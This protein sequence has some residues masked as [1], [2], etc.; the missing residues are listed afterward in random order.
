[1]KKTL[2]LLPNLL[3][4]QAPVGA[5]LPPRVGEAVAML[6]GLIAESE[7]GGRAYLSLFTDKPVHT[8][9]IALLN[10][11]TK[12]EDYAFLLDPIRKGET[13]GVVSDAGLPY[14][15]DPAA[16]LVRHA[17]NQGIEVV[18]FPGPSS[19]MHALAMSGYPGQ[20]FTFHGYL[21]KE[22]RKL[23]GEIREIENN[24]LKQGYTQIF[25]ESPHRNEMLLKTLLST[26]SDSVRLCAAV[27]LTGKTQ[28]I[29]EGTVKSWR[30]NPLPEIRKRPAIFLL[31]R[32]NQAKE[33]R[34]KKPT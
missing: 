13:W 10:K 9:P 29:F 3:D 28:E 18:T 12:P 23:I 14:L 2:Y 26:L 34:W 7:K 20:S 11:H 6:D 22:E 24:A 31:W 15:A 1:M 21:A 25:I 8:L 27:D 5:N 19:A 32:G 33:R 4:K 16:G 17:R 30:A